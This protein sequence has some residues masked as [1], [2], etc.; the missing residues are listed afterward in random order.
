MLETETSSIKADFLFISPGSYSDFKN[1]VQI[2][3]VINDSDLSLSDLNKLYG[4]FGKDDVLHFR[5]EINGTL[6][7]F[8][9]NNFYSKSD[10]KTIVEGDFIVKNAFNKGKGFSIDAK[11]SNLSSDYD[12]LGLLLPKKLFEKIPS[13]IKDLGAFKLSGESF[14]STEIIEASVQIQTSIGSAIADINMNNIDNVD[15]A[16]YNGHIKVMDFDSG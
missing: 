4:E 10:L 14:I 1:K 11:L 2:K 3:A 12:R 7:N 5:T 6:N 15:N 16:H 9:T 13:T 8:R